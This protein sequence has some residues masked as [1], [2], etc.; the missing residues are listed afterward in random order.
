LKATYTNDFGILLWGPGGTASNNRI[1]GQ[2]RGI[3]AYSTNNRILNNTIDVYEVNKN[4]EYN[5]CELSGSFGIQFEGSSRY[6]LATGNTVTTTADLCEARSFRVTDTPS[7]NGNVSRGNYYK[8]IRI[9]TTTKIA[10]AASFQGMDGVLM[11]GD[12][13]EADGANAEIAWNGGQ[14]ITLR[15]VTF[16]KGTNPASNYATLVFRSG[17]T[18]PTTTTRRAQMTLQDP[19]FLNGASA[20]SFIMYPIGYNGWAVPS[21]YTVQWT[22]NL[23][24]RDRLLAAVSGATVTISDNTGATWSL[25]TDANG[26]ITP[27]LL[28]QFR[29]YNTT[30]GVSLDARTYTVKVTKNTCTYSAPLGLTSTI[31]SI[32]T[33]PCL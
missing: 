21:S 18:N 19:K 9:G 15:N 11:D 2:S 17:D 31:N 7:G 1:R 25:L 14:N 26:R 22:Y 20:N 24:V 28:T 10:A 30:S 4:I 5:G 12:T 27:L 23:T 33:L 6:A 29:R 16:V 8:A 13:L 32:V 3:L